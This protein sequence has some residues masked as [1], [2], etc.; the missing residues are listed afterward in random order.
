MMKNFCKT[1]SII[2]KMAILSNNPTAQNS[3]KSQILKSI[4]AIIRITLTKNLRIK[5]L[6][7]LIMMIMNQKILIIL[8]NHCNKINLHLVMIYSINKLIFKNKT[9]YLLLKEIDQ[10]RM[11]KPNQT[12]IAIFLIQK[13]PL[14]IKLFNRLIINDVYFMNILNYKF[15]RIY[16]SK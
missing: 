4:P 6:K 3:F 8:K 10:S 1:N 11:I 16:K 12:P 13:F 5:P 15:L 14:L 9:N 2:V 7:M